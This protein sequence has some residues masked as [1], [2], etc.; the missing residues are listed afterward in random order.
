MLSN[1][2]L[3]YEVK[4]S[5]SKL[6]NRRSYI[7]IAYYGHGTGH[8]SYTR[9]H[10]RRR[11]SGGHT[12][13]NAAGKSILKMGFIIR[14]TNTVSLRWQW[15][16]RNAL[17]VRGGGEEEDDDHRFVL[18][19]DGSLTMEEAKTT[20]VSGSEESRTSAR[21]EAERVWLELYQIG[22]LGFGRVSFT[23]I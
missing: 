9:I 7:M 19:R 20:S 22:H 2:Y 1:A 10:T 18:E 15:K 5:L 3:A 6:S 21:V 13:D 23:G 4:M 14:I 11:T 16:K 12:R 8:S 17:V